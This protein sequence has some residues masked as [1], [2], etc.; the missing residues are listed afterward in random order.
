[1]CTKTKIIW[2]T[3]PVIWNERDRSFFILCHFLPSH[4]LTNWKTKTLKKMKKASRDVIILHICTKNHNHM[5]YASW[6][7]K[8]TRHNFL[9]FCTICCPF[10]PLTTWKIKILKK[11]EKK[12]EISSFY[13]CVPQITIIW[14]IVPKLWSMADRIFCHLGQLFILLP[15]WQPKKSYRYPHF[16]Q[17]VKKKKNDNHMLHCCWDTTHDIIFIFHFGLLFTLLPPNDPKNS[18]S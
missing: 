15:L 9:S 1:M 3:V 10:L 12:L 14:C 17:S 6:D 11:W 5:M 8:C 2:G 13:N 16:T 4:P 18:R 7:M